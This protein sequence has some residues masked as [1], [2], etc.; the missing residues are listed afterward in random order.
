[1]TQ[2]MIGVGPLAALLLGLAL[3][4]PAC[5]ALGAASGIIGAGFSGYSILQRKEMIQKLEDLTKRVEALA[6]KEVPAPP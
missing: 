3:L 6:P 1:M 5:V 2:R 4:T